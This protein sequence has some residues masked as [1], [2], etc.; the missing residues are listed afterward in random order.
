M[1]GVITHE[2]E[3]KTE[4]KWYFI[5]IGTIVFTLISIFV[6]RHEFL[7]LTHYTI[8]DSGYYETWVFYP[9]DKGIATGFLH[10][11][12]FLYSIGVQSF[13]FYNST[14]LLL[15]IYF[16]SI[17][18]P[19]SAKGVTWARACIAFNPYLLISIMGPTKEINLIFFSLAAFFLFLRGPVILKVLSIVPAFGAM[20]IRPQFGLLILVAFTCVLL[21]KVIKKP[22][23]L[24]VA[25]L[26]LFLFFN[27][28][29]FINGIISNSGGDE[30]EFFQ[31]S[32]YYEVALVLKV[33]QENPIFQIFALIIKM[34]LVMFA[35]IARPNTLSSPYVPLLDWGYTFMGWLLFPLNLSFILLFFNKRISQSPKLNEAGQLIIIYAFL[36]IFSTIVS[37]IIQARYLFPYSPFIAACFMLHQ[38][39]I[40]NRILIFSFSLILLT[41]ILTALFLPKKWETPTDESA[42][43][44]SWF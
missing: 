31:S 9:R 6:A 17:F 22:I 18:A 33:M 19:F 1:H 23:S 11:N 20:A 2:N 3:K 37:P 29:P 27:S 39:H 30:L 25:I 35:P 16:C 12:T 40:R 15:S 5:Q 42:T 32:I 24:C 44:I 43:Y 4:Y 38:V 8:P 21:L 28:I 7:P 36:G 14:L 34:V 10:M 26:L 41:F 13:V